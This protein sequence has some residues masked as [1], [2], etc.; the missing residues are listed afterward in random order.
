MDYPKINIAVLPLN[1]QDDST[2]Y[3][4]DGISDALIGKLSSISELK[5]TSRTSSFQFRGQSFSVKQVADQLGVNA[6]I[7]G[8]ARFLSGKM[9]IRVNLIRTDLDE[10]V[11]SRAW[12]DQVNQLF[13]I[14]KRIAASVAENIRDHLS[15]F[16]LSQPIYRPSKSVDI[17]VYKLFLKANYLQFNWV[18]SDSLEALSLYNEVS[19]KAPDFYDAEINKIACYAYLRAQ[20]AI[21]SEE[22]DMAM[23]KIFASLEIA[24]V[25]NA[26]LY[27]AKAGYHFWSSW[28]FKASF[29]ELRKSLDLNPSHSEA[30][31]LLGLMYALSGKRRLSKKHADFA[32]QLDPLSA[33]KHITKAWGLYAL[34]KFEEVIISYERAMKLNPRIGG[35]GGLSMKVK[36]LI[37]MGKN[38]DR[39]Y[40]EVRENEN[41]APF[42]R[43][44]LLGLLAANAGNNEVA[45]HH[46]KNLTML[47]EIDRNEQ[48]SGFL[49]QIFN[50]QGKKNQALKW[51]KRGFDN[52]DPMLV[53]LI[54]DPLLEKIKNSPEFI[55]IQ[56][57]LRPL[58]SEQIE[59][60]VKG[61]KNPSIEW[62]AENKERLTQLMKK[63][64]PYLN[65]SLS[66]PELAVSMGMT[67]NMLSWLI[68]NEF[69]QNFSDFINW[70]RVEAFKIKVKDPSLSHLSLLGLAFECGFNSKSSFN[71]VFKRMTGLTPKMFS[72]QNQ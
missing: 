35:G 66:L 65:A 44:G 19:E 24:E 57:H 58:G 68:N 4:S 56:N 46:A 13:E 69:N 11:W 51:L 37:A 6:I 12:E 2:L 54:V 29:E 32:I 27:V 38:S 63:E 22:T 62:A 48:I 3:L 31:N 7:E 49:M 23:A 10:V 25:Q 72:K 71:S 67:T 15:H 36:S 60:G 39:L 30:H 5:V 28:D 16:D 64:K 8:S 42:I 59:E 18:I 53:G 20:M 21:S 61:K 52:R 34:E 43:E 26:D 33:N 14:E 1:N 41:I 47:Y 17:P 45:S 55:K 9:K 70:Y 50:Q 40:E